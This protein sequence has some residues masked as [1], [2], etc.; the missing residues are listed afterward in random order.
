MRILI[1][2]DDPMIVRLVE[3]QVKRWGH[4]LIVAHDGF[5]AIAALE[6]DPTVRLVLSDWEMPGMTGVELCRRI[7][8][9]EGRQYTYFILLT[10]KDASEDLIH[11]FQAG[12][13]EFITKPFRPREL[14]MRLDAAGRLLAEMSKSRSLRPPPLAVERGTVVAGRYRL[15]DLLG[16]GGMGTV[17][18]AEHIGLLCKV[19]VKFLRPEHA[20]T[21]SFRTRFEAEARVAARVVS[22][23]TVRVYD[24]GIADGGVPYMVMEHLRGT[25]LA[26]VIAEHGPMDPR[27][28][29][30]TIR[31]I[32]TALA[33]AHASGVIHRDVKPENILLAEDDLAK[34]K[35]TAKLIDFGV[36]KVLDDRAPSTVERPA[37]KA[38]ALTE[39]GVIVG[40]LHYLSPEYLAGGAPPNEKLDLWGLAVSAYAAIV[41]ALPFEGDTFLAVMGRVCNE[42]LPVPSIRLPTVPAGF[43]DWFAR[44]CS[45]DPTRRFA[46]AE[47]LSRALDEVCDPSAPR[48]PSPAPAPASAPAIAPAVVTVRVRLPDQGA[49]P[50]ETAEDGDVGERFTCAPT[51]AAIYRPAEAPPES[52]HLPMARWSRLGGLVGLALMLLAVVGIALAR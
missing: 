29:A 13:D 6:A 9:L 20:E 15:T 26:E 48:V 51:A 12:V 34:E 21:A 38:M 52:L 16:A 41:G 44:A 17:W 30:R 46:S 11:A 28:V 2:D 18:E 22:P 33:R 35:I 3:A 37:V 32:A 39:V 43:D 23:Y 42:P 19:A 5:Q 45:R 50:K 4:D 8:E 14:Q 31:E 1:A 10:A 36:A 40:T 47:E 49:W 24:Y 25:S 27:D 7:R